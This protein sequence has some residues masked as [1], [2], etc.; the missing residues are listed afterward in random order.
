MTALLIVAAAHKIGRD[1]A[2]V[3]PSK[4]VQEA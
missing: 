4:F 2:M 3:L 1:R